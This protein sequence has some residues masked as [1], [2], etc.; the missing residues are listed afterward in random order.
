MCLQK[1]PSATPRPAMPRGWWDPTSSPQHRWDPTSSPQHQ[2]KS[3]DAEHTHTG[4]HIV[5]AVEKVREA[6]GVHTGCWKDDDLL[7][8]SSSAIFRALCNVS[9][10]SSCPLLRGQEE[11]GHFSLLSNETRDLR[12]SSD[13]IQLQALSLSPLLWDGHT[14]VTPAQHHTAYKPFS[15]GQIYW[16]IPAVA[17]ETTHLSNP[18]YPHRRSSCFQNQG[19]LCTQCSMY[20]PSSCHTPSPALSSLSLAH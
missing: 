20:S 1:C 8:S 4:A 6:Y 3:C 15:W 14:A 19:G 2:P 10:V 11:Q 9:Q 12:A 16:D 5:C 13:V 18:V 7:S 17:G